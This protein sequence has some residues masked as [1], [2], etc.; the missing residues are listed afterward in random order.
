MQE[1]RSGNATL[2]FLGPLC[3]WAPVGKCLPFWEEASLQL[4]LF[5]N[6]ITE[7]H[8]LVVSGANQ[9]DHQD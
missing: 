9:V 3:V 7:A 1:A 5:G 8:L 4:I 6:A 2:L